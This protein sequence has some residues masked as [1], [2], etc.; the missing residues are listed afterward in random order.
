MKNSGLLLVLSTIIG[1]LLVCA[2]LPLGGLAILLSNNNDK[3]CGVLPL[4]NNS[5]QEQKVSGKGPDRLVI[6]EVNGVIGL[7]DS[8]GG[9]LSHS[10]LLAQIKQATEDPLVKAVVLRVVSPGGGVVASNEIH[11]ALKKLRAAKKHLVVSMGS[12]AASGGYYISTAS[13]RIYAN[14]DTF[15]GSLGVIIN[16]LNYRQAFETLGLRQVVLK[17]GKLKDI[18]SPTRDLTPEEEK[19]LQSVVNEAYEG[20]VDVIV[21]GRKLERKEVKR[22]ADG[23]IYTGRQAL[24][25]KLIDELGGLEDAIEGAK[26][27]A[28]LKDALVIRYRSN[29]SLRNLLLNKM[30]E[31]SKPADPLGLRNITQSNG[32]RLEYL[33]TP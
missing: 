9:V 10:D 25:L 1:I 21:E 22:I 14:P 26:K 32:P 12:V 5:W 11:Q 4:T 31:S 29:I 30:A 24:E 20:F 7:E 19:V 15:T 27:I 28:D 6:I 33:L 13:E 16:L 17:S 2:A 18:G 23:R 8:G 3:S